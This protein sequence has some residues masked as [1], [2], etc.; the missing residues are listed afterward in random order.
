[1]GELYAKYPEDSDVATL[2]AASLMNLSPWYYWTPDARPR[3]GVDVDAR[4]AVT[5]QRGHHAPG[6]AAAH[7]R[8]GQEGLDQFFLCGLR[9]SIPS[10][11]IA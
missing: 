1:M 6:E 11:G 3:G 10:Y 2:Y 8:G 4:I 5:G 7:L 9:F